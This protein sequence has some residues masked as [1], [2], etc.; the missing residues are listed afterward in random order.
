MSSSTLE[1]RPLTATIGAEIFGVDLTQALDDSTRTAIHQALLDHLVVFFRDQPMT[2]DQHVAMGLRFG[3][4]HIHSSAPCIDNRP[5]LMKVHADADSPFAEG[6]AWHTD[7]SCDT[8]PPMASILHLTTV[9][10]A[11]GDTL[12]ANMYAAYDALSDTMKRMIDP[13]TALHTS[14]VYFGRYE[15]V[16]GGLR[17]EDWAK[18]EHPVVR[19]HPETGRKLIYVNKPFT[20]HI[21]G[22]KPAESQ[23]LLNFLY[24]HSAHPQFHCRF[25]WQENSVAF[26]D[27]RCTQ[28]LA[29]WDYFP[30][31]RSGIRVTIQG[32]TPFH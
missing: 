10:P 17:R 31:V 14:D 21:V 15:Q 11:G 32:D 19:T 7:V 12:F 28:H 1:V 2:P 27:N 8:E 20:K 23:A 9:P 29:T 22:M 5:E 13:L 4:L 25:R 16:G 26:W 30:Q 3:D 18:A 24:E 6:T